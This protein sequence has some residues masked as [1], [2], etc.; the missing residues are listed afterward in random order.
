MEFGTRFFWAG[1][2]IGCYACHD[3]PGS[4]DPTNNRPPSVT[5]ASA[6]TNAQPVQIRLSANDPDGD[7]LSLRVVSQPFHGTV[8]LAGQTATYFPELAFSG[9]DTFTFAAWDGQINS[10]LGTVTVAVSGGGGGTCTLTCDATVPAGGR[11]GTAVAFTATAQATHC[12]GLPTWAWTFGDSGTSTLQNPTH[13]YA[14]AGNYDW[15]LRVAVSGQSC[16]K[17]GR[18]GITTLAPPPRVTRVSRLANPF[19]VVITGT[20]FQ[21]ALQVYIGNQPWTALDRRG[22][23]RVTLREGDALRALFPASTWVRLRLVNPDGQSTTVEYNRT[24]NQW[25]PAS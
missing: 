4:E 23:T 21:P 24:T 16:Q 17:G 20:G 22:S 25:R 15:S 1:F 2:Q 13:T 6:A 18:I 8:G 14:N 5:N 12:T 7:A 9:T 10:N 3:G 11:T 19:R